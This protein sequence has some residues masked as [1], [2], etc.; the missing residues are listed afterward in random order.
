MG[1]FGVPRDGVQVLTEYGLKEETAKD[2]LIHNTVM[3]VNPSFKR[4]VKS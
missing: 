1:N 2:K 3:L 4:R